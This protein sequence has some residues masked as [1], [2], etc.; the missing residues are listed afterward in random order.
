MSDF[1]ELDFSTANLLLNINKPVGWSSAKVVSEVKKITKAKKVGHFG[2][3]DPFADGVLPI[4]INKVTKA[5]QY[6][7]NFSKKYYFQIR[8]GEF[9]DT[10][11][12]EGQVMQTS[13][14]RPSNNQINAVL[15]KFIG[16]IAQTPSRFSAIKINGNRAYELARKNIE[17]EVKSRQITVNSL[18][19]ISNNSEFGEFEVECLKGTY[20]RSLGRDIC[21]MLG[22]CGYLSVL[23]RLAVGKFLYN[24]T[25]SLDKLKNIVNYNS[26]SDSLDGS[27][28]SLSLVL[29]FM[30]EVKLDDSTAL[31]FKNGQIVNCNQPFLKQSFDNQVCLNQSKENIFDS[32]LQKNL[33]KNFFDENIVRVFDSNHELIG[34][35]DMQNDKLRPINVF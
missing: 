20:V 15:I 26:N 14:K 24:K 12:I 16:N 3:L 4:G 31:R 1:M 18:K 10:D 27:L 17:F 9:R 34:L 30:I 11:D 8:W 19:L 25:I 23:R 21:Q 2:T 22:V 33:D 28:F 32:S 13:A 7:T 29:D 5:G 6:V 35:A